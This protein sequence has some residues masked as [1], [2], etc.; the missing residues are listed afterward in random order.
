MRTLLILALGAATLATPVRAFTDLRPPSVPGSVA[1]ALDRARQDLGAPGMAIAVWSGGSIVAEAASGVRVAGSQ[2]AVQASDAFHIGSVTKSITAVL[3]ARLVEEGR[4]RWDETVADRLGEAVPD[5]SPDQ[6][7]VT[8]EMLLA[9]ESGAP[10]RLSPDQLRGV[11]QAP[12]LSAG[13]VAVARAVLASPPAGPRGVMV[14][15]NPGYV[16]AGSMIERA[17]GQSWE[18][19][20]GEKV[21]APL[22]LSSAGFGVPQGDG[23]VRGHRREGDAWVAIDPTGPAA[24]NPPFLRPAGGLSLSMR[25]LALFGADQ[26]KG[27]RGDAGA[28]LGAAAY[29]RLHAEHSDHQGLG[30]A[31]APD[32]SFDNSGSNGRWFAYVKVMPGEDLVVAVAANAYTPQMEDRIVRLVEEIRSL[33]FRP[34][35]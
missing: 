23:A 22:S 1:Q 27:V 21:L 12:D 24:D 13:R 4:L 33:G 15:S 5:I 20:V 18:D 26:L 29:A 25:D 6:R 32:G 30:W 14:Y 7:S 35:G 9:H 17:G 28:L 10:E 19:L 16:I 34:Q 3:A 2:D 31:Q 11:V 8:L